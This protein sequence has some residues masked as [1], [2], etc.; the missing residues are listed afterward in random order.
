M[1]K[2][3]VTILLCLLL[4]FST[5]QSNGAFRFCGQKAARTLDAIC[6]PTEVE[7]PC[8]NYEQASKTCCAGHC[9]FA[10]MK[11]Y[12]CSSLYEQNEGLSQES[13]ELD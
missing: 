4:C 2:S 11:R 12:C 13:S 7:P 3:K 6:P 10:D 5:I 8:H 1:S 9:S